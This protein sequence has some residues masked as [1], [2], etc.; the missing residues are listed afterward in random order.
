MPIFHKHYRFF[1][2]LRNAVGTFPKPDRYS[3]GVRLENTAL[4]IL[5][6]LLR[7]NAARGLERLTQLR[8]ASL[9]LDLLKILVRLAKDVK[10]LPDKTYLALEARLIEIG[11]MLGG[12][13]KSVSNTNR[14]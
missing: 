3:L 11:K 4:E 2:A 13:L 7:A 5:T 14:P 6:L 12:W 8:E 1:I 9:S 10:A